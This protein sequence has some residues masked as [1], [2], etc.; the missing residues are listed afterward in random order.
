MI[1]KAFR[2][3]AMDAAQINMWHKCFKDAW[4]SVESDPC[5]GRPASRTPENVERVWAAIYK[6]WQ[7]TV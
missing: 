4:E 2:E 1:Q 6:D 5:Y 3:D 7:L